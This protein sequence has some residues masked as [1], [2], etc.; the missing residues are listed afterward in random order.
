LFQFVDSAARAASF[1]GQLALIKSISIN[2]VDSA[3]DIIIMEGIC[4]DKTVGIG[5]I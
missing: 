3:E 1:V 2:N 5:Q 4:I